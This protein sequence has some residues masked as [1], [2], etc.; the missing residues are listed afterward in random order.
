MS[1]DKF[2][3]EIKRRVELFEEDYDPSS[4]EILSSKMDTAGLDPSSTDEDFM[5]H[6]K[7]SLRKHEEPLNEEHWEIM[8]GE[9]DRLD[10][11]R[12]QLYFAK[13]IEAAIVLLLLM[14]YFNY[15]SFKNYPRLQVD[16]SFV[17]SQ[18]DD[19]S[20]ESIIAQSFVPVE[21]Q[22]IIPPSFPPTSV[23][24]QQADLI[25]WYVVL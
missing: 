16:E 18:I 21:E 14:T 1:L 8:K 19:H 24:N 4:W 5:P 15:Q 11:K 20:I 13:F 9:L 23:V 7:E 2:D 25:A 3:K 22:N 6:V 17:Q 12:R 10:M